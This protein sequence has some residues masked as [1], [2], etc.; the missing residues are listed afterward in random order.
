MVRCHFSVNGSLCVYSRPSLEGLPDSLLS[1]DAFASLGLIPHT[2][3]CVIPRMSFLYLAFLRLDIDVSFLYAVF[4]VRI[5]TDVLSVIRNQK[6]SFCPLITGKTS[7][8]QPFPAGP[9]WHRPLCS[10]WLLIGA[11]PFFGR[12]FVHARSI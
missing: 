1:I 8:Q 2:L 3:S 10:V 5:L 6:L 7:F 11:L 4:K 12:P 9:G